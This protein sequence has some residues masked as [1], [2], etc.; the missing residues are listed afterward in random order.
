[1]TT[2]STT[3]PATCKAF[4][5]SIGGRKRAAEAIGVPISTFNQW[6]DGRSSPPSETIARLAMDMIIHNKSH[7]THFTT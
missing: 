4:A 6:C 2:P 3:F 1:M 7:N 5:K